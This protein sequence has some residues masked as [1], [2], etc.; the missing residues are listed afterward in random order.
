ME[1]NESGARKIGPYEIIKE[2]GAGGMGKVYLASHPKLQRRVAIKV[3]LASH[4]SEKDRARFLS[5]A[6]LTAQLQHPNIVGVYDIA[7]EGD[8]DYIVMEFIEG[9]SL[10]AVLKKNRPDPRKSLELIRDVAV[11][12]D[13]AHQN[14][15]VHRDLKPAN[16]MIETKTGR[17][18]VMDFGL[19]KNIKQDK[20]LSKSGDLLGTPRYMAPEQARGKVREICPAT[21][22]YALGGIMYEMLTGVCAVE[23]T[24]SLQ[25]IYNIMYQDVV[26]LCKRNHNLTQDLETICMKALEKEPTRRYVRAGALA[27]DIERFLRGEATLA[28]PHGI[29]YKGWQTL[30][31]NKLTSILLTLFVLFA[32][33]GSVWGWYTIREQQKESRLLTTWNAWCHDFEKALAQD[34]RILPV[35]DRLL[36][37]ARDCIST[38]G[39]PLL[40]KWQDKLNALERSKEKGE[41]V[42]KIFCD[43]HQF[44]Y[45]DTDQ[46]CF[47]T[48][49]HQYDAELFAL[50]KA[51]TTQL[52]FYEQALPQYEALQER[53]VQMKTEFNATQYLPLVR[54][55]KW[56][57]NVPK[58]LV[59][60][61]QRTYERIPENAAWI[62][63]ETLLKKWQQLLQQAT[64]CKAAGT[65]TQLELCRWYTTYALK[66]KQRD[67]VLLDIKRYLESSVES[68]YTHVKEL[69]TRLATTD[70]N[71]QREAIYE[72]IG[73]LHRICFMNCSYAPAYYEL[74]RFLHQS[75]KVSEAEVSY[76]QTIA[77]EQFFLA[78]YYKNEILFHQHRKLTQYEQKL[79]RLQDLKREA[80]HTLASYKA[81]LKKETTESGRKRL[82]ELTGFEQG[83]LDRLNAEIANKEK[84]TAGEQSLAHQKE[85]L[86]QKQRLVDAVLNDAKE[87][88]NHAGYAEM[89]EF[90]ET[91]LRREQTLYGR[92]RFGKIDTHLHFY[93]TPPT[94]TDAIAA[95]E[96]EEDKGDYQNGVACYKKLLALLESVQMKREK[97]LLASTAYLQG[98]IYF[99]LAS[100]GTTGEDNVA[101]ITKALKALQKAVKM[102]PFYP[103]AMQALADV[104]YFLRNFK[105]SEETYRQLFDI[106]LIN[107][108]PKN[109]RPWKFKDFGK[110]IVCL[111][112][113]KKDKEVEETLTQ[114]SQRWEDWK[115]VHANYP[116]DA[117]KTSLLEQYIFQAFTALKKNHTQRLQTLLPRLDYRQWHYTP[118]IETLIASMVS[119]KLG[120]TEQAKETFASLFRRHGELNRMTASKEGIAFFK[121][122]P[123]LLAG[124]ENP[125]LAD[126]AIPL[127]MPILDKT[128]IGFSAAQYWGFLALLVRI[129]N[130]PSF[131]QYVLECIDKNLD[132]EFQRL[133]Q[134]I[135]EVNMPISLRSIFLLFMK[136]SIDV[137]EDSL[138]QIPQAQLTSPEQAYYKAIACYR[139][140]F[141]CQDTQQRER[142]LEQSLENLQVV[143]S[144]NPGVMKHHYAAAVIYGLLA[145]KTAAHRDKAYLHLE[146]AARLKDSALPEA[147][148]DVPWKYTKR[149]PAFKKLYKE[150]SKRFE[151]ILK[152]PSFYEYPWEKLES[153]VERYNTSGNN[154]DASMLLRTYACFMEKCWQAAR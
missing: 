68:Q 36:V 41:E 108:D 19:A 4:A 28:K 82:K 145:A 113:Q 72:A 18:V 122:L 47:F 3:M 106:S 89:K 107:G 93:F 138:M 40:A 142:L 58:D 143:L 129:G 53:Y 133:T 20:A 147:P 35:C 137:N 87:A 80:L 94:V 46:P 2:L 24:T 62:A 121:L 81:D 102:Q 88:Q 54:D 105:A 69:H 98:L 60:L 48:R 119:L 124:Y 16:I 116:E 104:Y 11:A 144:Q 5:E 64:D 51:F 103:E 61:F 83:E 100:I 154:A 130:D 139:R 152:S 34:V 77:R 74:A 67:P 26:P 148:L 30:R 33:V 37:Q 92:T 97:A 15:I 114:S 6:R 128:L 78:Y 9:E 131:C 39:E 141:Q 59:Y 42:Q 86:N 21:D 55:S 123:E 115:N 75:G 43:W 111:V 99:D 76:D 112:N 85:R 126:P 14:N 132:K 45:E 12:I 84:L 95:E 1:Q 90:Y 140:T 49:W 13:F 153:R 17:A 50:W 136:G 149:D 109:N 101:Y 70:V 63:Y 71:L 120:Q 23:G 117:D 44:L 32:A 52:Q 31:Q 27:D 29:C 110:F 135:P 146:L 79:A 118:D 66:L 134:S 22:V 151:E 57:S 8:C 73:D 91:W 125:F 127:R 38:K 10:E 96:D 65:P 7:S 150:D 56:R 25:I